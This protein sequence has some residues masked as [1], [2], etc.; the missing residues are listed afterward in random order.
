MNIYLGLDVTNFVSRHHANIVR[1]LYQTSSFVFWN[2]LSPWNLNG[3]FER[4]FLKCSNLKLGRLLRKMEPIWAFISVHMILIPVAYYC[5][6]FLDLKGL[7]FS[8]Q[9]YLFLLFDIWLYL[10][11]IHFFLSCFSFLVDTRT[12]VCLL[13]VWLKTCTNKIEYFCVY[14]FS[15]HNHLL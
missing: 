4:A 1:V 6:L 3:T 10:F 13:I 7:E 5:F 11:C 9:Y 12:L 14:L 15:F 2:K 8:T